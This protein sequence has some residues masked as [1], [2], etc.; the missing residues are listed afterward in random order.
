MV[1]FIGLDV[2]T[3]S[4]KAIVYNRQSSSIV[5]RG[6][7]AYKV[8]SERPGQAE[9]HPDVW[10]DACKEVIRQALQHCD[11]S[12][13]AAIAVSGQQ[14]GLVVLDVN[15]TVIRPA[16]LWCDLESVHEAEELSEIFKT[17][18]VP[19]FTGEAGEERRQLKP[20]VFWFLL[21][22]H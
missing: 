20:S 14:H 7:V 4:T 17:T 6:S 15:N 12:K 1:L 9:Q 5:A 10:I 2:G 21:R 8:N 13:V 22:Q 18:I 3:Q 11:G 19:S 16:K